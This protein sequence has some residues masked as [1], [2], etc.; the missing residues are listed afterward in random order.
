MAA[1]APHAMTTADVMAEAE[2]GASAIAR[3]LGRQVELLGELDRRRAWGDEG[4]TS[5]GAWAVERFGVSS[6][7]AKVWAHVGER[8]YDLPELAAGLREGEL[9]LDKVAAVV[10]LATPA[11]DA[12][13][14]R[15]ARHCSVH[16]LRQLARRSKGAPNSKDQ[17]DRRSL[18]WN[19][20]RRTISVQLPADAYAECKAILEAAGKS[21]SAGAET[22]W[23][24]RLADALVSLLRQQRS[25]GT[26][27]YLVVIHA[28]MSTFVDGDGG[29]GGGGGES[30]DDGNESRSDSGHLWS[31][32]GELERGGLLDRATVRRVACDASVVLALDDDV[33]HTMYEGRVKRFP[34]GPQ[35]REIWRRDRTCRF[36]ACTNAT[37]TNVHHLREWHAG[38]KTDLGNLALLC[39]AHHHMI[40]E[41]RWLVSGDAN[42]ELSFHA[43]TGRVIT[44]RPS[45]HWGRT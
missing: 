32:G 44:S 41:N 3:L 9:S 42:G 16:Q 39:E 2:Q 1:P 43:P 20:E 5:L 30:T 25:G 18:R 29:G 21:I 17:A 13:W 6:S 24:Q 40:H 15:Q 23:D 26:A 33:G 27:Q 14:R 11:T 10:D 7:T 45:P 31:V 19:D 22:R 8:L 4:A 37:F 38:G 28:P 12:S 36:G 34:T 35:R